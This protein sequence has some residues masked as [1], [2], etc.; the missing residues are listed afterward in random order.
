MKNL[1]NFDYIFIEHKLYEFY[2]DVDGAQYLKENKTF[3]PI[4]S[5]FDMTDITPLSS[6]HIKLYNTSDRNITSGSIIHEHRHMK[7]LIDNVEHVLHS[8]DMIVGYTSSRVIWARVRTFYENTDKLKILYTDDP[9]YIKNTNAYHVEPDSI[10]K[11]CKCGDISDDNRDNA[12]NLSKNYARGIVCR[13]DKTGEPLYTKSGHQLIK[14][15][16]VCHIEEVLGLHERDLKINDVSCVE[17]IDK[18]DKSNCVS[19]KIYLNPILNIDESHS[20]LDS[21]DTIFQ[22]T[23]TR[24]EPFIV[25]FIKPYKGTYYCGEVLDNF[26]VIK[27]FDLFHSYEDIENLHK[28]TESLDKCETL[29]TEN[30]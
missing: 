30:L 18:Y 5:R 27:W 22:I 25:D 13:S 28:F 10:F 4:I 26:S 2:I 29:E 23:C 8:V 16:G 14:E 6:D 11:N 21:N 15:C 17:F 12:K 3:T 19:F 9:R 24:L 1:G 20:Q 7:C